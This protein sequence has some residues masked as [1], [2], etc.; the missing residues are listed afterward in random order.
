MGNVT[1]VFLKL[2]RGIIMTWKGSILFEM[3]YEKKSIHGLA[4]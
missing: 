1:V 2:L 3:Y 4:G